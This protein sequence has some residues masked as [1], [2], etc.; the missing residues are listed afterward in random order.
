MPADLPVLAI[1]ALHVTVAEEDVA[2]AVFAGDNRLFTVMGADRGDGK[3]CP[4][5]AVSVPKMNAVGPALTGTLVAVT[6]DR[7]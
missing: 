4:G 2:D 3:I 6:E 5:A 7:K 1:D